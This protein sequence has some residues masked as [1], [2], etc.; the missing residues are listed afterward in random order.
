MNM[1]QAVKQRFLKRVDEVYGGRYGATRTTT[2]G[3][4]VAWDEPH[5][6]KELELADKIRK[7][8]HKKQASQSLERLKA[9][10]KVPTKAGKKLFE[11]FIKEANSYKKQEDELDTKEMLN[12]YRSA[13]HLSFSKWIMFINDTYNSKI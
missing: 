3:R 13:S 8:L 10:N 5:P 11:Q 2:S 12:I 1:D 7:S 4:K 6:D 9:K